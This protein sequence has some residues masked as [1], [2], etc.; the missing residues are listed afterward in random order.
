MATEP[1]LEP[2]EHE[3]PTKSRDAD[4]APWSASRYIWQ[5]VAFARARRLSADLDAAKATRQYAQEP[6][7][8]TIF[9]EES[10][11]IEEAIQ[12]AKNIVIGAQRRGLARRIADWWTGR[13]MDATWSNLHLAEQ[14]LLL[15][16]PD[17]ILRARLPELSAAVGSDLPAGSARIKEYEELLDRLAVQTKPSA[18]PT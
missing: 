11:K 16:L 12:T 7:L 2:A 5:E 1:T 13:L 6:A 9:D 14:R 18:S 10:A 15:I 17:D 4:G 8:A 3:G